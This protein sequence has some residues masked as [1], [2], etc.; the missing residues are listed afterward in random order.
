MTPRALGETESSTSLLSSDI[1]L[2]DLPSARSRSS[3]RPERSEVRGWPTTAK[4]LRETSPGLPLRIFS[5]V[6][7]VLIPT[8]FIVLGI[9][10]ACLKDKPRSSTSEVIVQ[11]AKYAATFWPI[12]F[13]AVV[14]SM[15]R[16]IA[17]YRAERGVKLGVLE[18]FMRCQTL[19]S[20]VKEI[21]GLRVFSLWTAILLPIWAFSPAGG[22]AVDRILRPQE[23]FTATK[24][25]L[26]YYPDT[27]VSALTLRSYVEGVDDVKWSRSSMLMMYGG[28][29]SD[30]G[31]A[32]ISSN[33]S[34]AYFNDVFGRITPPKAINGTRRDL[35]GNARI[36][37]LRLVPGFDENHPSDWINIPMDQVAPFASLIGIPIR[38]FSDTDV[39]NMTLELSSVYHV[40][41]CSAWGN[42]SQW[43]VDHP[44]WTSPAL[45][46]VFGQ[47]PNTFLKHLSGNA[48]SNSET[49][50]MLGARTIDHGMWDNYTICGVQTEYVDVGIECS[51]LHFAEELDCMATRI[52]EADTL[53]GAS[54][55]TA[56]GTGVWALQ[57]FPEMTSLLASYDHEGL[58]P[59]EMYLRDPT[60]GLSPVQVRDFRGTSMPVFQTRLAMIL[61]TWWHVTLNQTIFLGSDDITP[62]TMNDTTFGHGNKLFGWAR[63]SGNWRTPTTPTYQIIRHWM[64]LYIAATTVLTLCAIV[65]IVL[66]SRIRAP[67][68]LGSV[69]T[70]TR[71][72][73]YVA[74]PPG[75]SGLE[76]TER[77]RLL[78]DMWV[79]IQDVRPG[80][81][82]GKIAFSDDK[83]LGT[84]LK[85]DRLYE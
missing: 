18:M 60:E 38:G 85:W 34:G 81:E 47:Y 62:S 7:I 66:Q 26:V 8:I 3:E 83:G 61:N 63:T 41:D 59:L 20:T 70:L 58:G 24:V 52:R 9:L 79:R 23:N 36:P 69:S 55:V 50:I 2:K 80:D 1:A 15:A 4:K 57:G 56:P 33:G 28:A 40:L 22:I 13:A 31:A 46:S 72:S 5:R 71:D 82:V 51:R 84:R 54:N 10:I 77:A 44:E 30:P 64:A 21:L 43:E 42:Y 67:D 32:V 78:K 11:A 35:W 76:S 53:P 73:P 29:L 75:G 17:L 68:I 6:F 12:A 74:A 48:T 27:N 37:F 65:T 19:F 14:G 16:T 25:P 45:G 39:G 49:T